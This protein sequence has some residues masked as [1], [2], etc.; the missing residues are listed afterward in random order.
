MIEVGRIY[1]IRFT[2]PVTFYPEQG[3]LSF[4]RETVSYPAGELIPGV[5]VTSI[6]HAGHP[7]LATYGLRWKHTVE[8]G[9]VSIINVNVS[10]QITD[11][12]VEEQAIQ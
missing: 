7:G 11:L 9:I 12:F 1:T 8:P 4:G 3:P 2:T 10:V 6:E 5:T